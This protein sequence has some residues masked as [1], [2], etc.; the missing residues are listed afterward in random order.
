[1]DLYMLW[2]GL[3]E[4]VLNSAEEETQASQTGHAYIGVLFGDRKVRVKQK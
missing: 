4:E 3:Q 1:M 2:Q